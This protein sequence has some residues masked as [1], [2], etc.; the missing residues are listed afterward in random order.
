[1]RVY[2][3]VSRS[4]I[5]RV[6]LCA[7]M[8][9]TMTAS[10]G[11]YAPAVP[12]TNGLLGYW[13]T[14]G[15]AVVHIDHCGSDVCMT[16]VTISEKAPGVIDARNPD[17]ALRRRPVCKMEIGSGFELKDADHGEKG[18]IYDPE[19]GKTYKASISSD[20]NTLSLR[21]YI[22]FKALGR[23][24]TWKRTSADSATCVGTTH[25]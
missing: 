12:V 14:N 19:S 1:M 6:S 7:A 9:L 15:G 21:G 8:F 23:T 17:P 22:G 24:Q 18:R 13:S 10:Y 16:V 11:Q 2:Q 20:G 4:S 25:R 3:K 5:C